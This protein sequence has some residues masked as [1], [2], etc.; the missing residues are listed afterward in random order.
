MQLTTEQLKTYEDQGYLFF[1]NCFSPEEVKK[2]KAEVPDIYAKDLPGKVL[3]NDGKTVRVLNGVHNEKKLFQRLVQ[4]SKVIRPIMQILGSAVYVHQF[5][6]NPKKA[7]DGEN[8]Q[9]HQ[10]S[11]Y[12]CQEDGIP[13]PRIANAVIFLDEVNEFNGPLMLI[14]GSQKEGIIRVLTEAQQ[15]SAAQDTPDWIMTQT[16]K[17]KYVI[18]KDTLARLL[19]RYGSIVAPK[20]PAGSV[21]FFHP[22]CVHGSASNMSPYDRTIIVINYNSVENLPIAEKILRPEFL[23]SRDYRGIK[24][25]SEEGLLV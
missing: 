23:A 15:N 25:L 17:L 14:P 5:K 22:N 8:W 11:I 24:P 13:K 19:D 10:D 6:I 1:P 9:W 7:F 12:L 16:T 3:E 4:H 20:G 2:M 18:D 21:L